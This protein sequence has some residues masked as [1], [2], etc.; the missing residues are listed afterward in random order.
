[1]TKQTFPEVVAED[2]GWDAQLESWRDIFGTKPFPVVAFANNGALPAANQND[3]GLAVV[4][5]DDGATG[6]GKILVISN[7]PTSNAYKKIGTQAAAITSLVD[8][9]GGAAAD[10]TIGVVN[11]SATAADAVKE[12]ATKVNEIL[13][14]L[15][16]SSLI[17]D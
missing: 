9:S 2:L 16:A 5:A 12:L 8:N 17:D 4:T 10:G 15:R 14:K 11:S 13:T 3:D 1:M 7:S 6:T